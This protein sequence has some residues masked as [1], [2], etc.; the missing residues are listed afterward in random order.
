MASTSPKTI[1]DWQP[2]A[3]RLPQTSAFSD[4]MQ[5]TLGLTTRL[6][7]QLKRRPSTLVAG[8]VQ[9]LMWLLLF[10]ALFQNIPKDEASRIADKFFPE[11]GFNY[12]DYD[13]NETDRTYNAAPRQESYVRT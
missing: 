13:R 3:D 5:E 2:R 8:I 10:G 7:I 6:F 9:P 12:A 4:F 11:R 1:A